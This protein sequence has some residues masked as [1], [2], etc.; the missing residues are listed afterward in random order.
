M[1]RATKDTRT[2]PSFVRSGTTPP[3]VSKIRPTH[4][5]RLAIVYV[6]QSSHRQVL[7]NRESTE[8]QYGLT[9]LAAS[10]GWHEDRILIIDDDQGQSGSTAEGRVG[11]QRLLAEVSLNHVGLVLGIEMS[12]LARSCKDWYH[13]LELCGVFQSLLADQDGLYDPA[14]YNDRLLLGLKGTMSEA[15][16]HIIRSR[17]DQGRRNKASRGELFGRL[18]FGYVFDSAGE[19]VKDP[20]E[21]VRSRVELIFEKFDEI[22][23]VRG[24]LL[25]LK[26]NQIKCPFVRYTQPAMGTVEWRYMSAATLYAL[27]KHPF[28]A[29]A[30]AWG[31]RKVDHRRRRPGQPSTG[32]ILQP[33]D[34]WDVLIR[35]RLPA[36]I[37]WDKYVAIQEQVRQNKST[38]S[39]PGA[40]RTS[41]LAGIVECGRCGW[42]MRMHQHS[43]C[44]ARQYQCPSRM[45]EHDYTQCQRLRTTVLDDLVTEKLFKAIEP[46]AL[47]LSLAAAANADAEGKRLLDLKRQELDRAKYLS[48]KA[49]RQY[50]AVDPENRLVAAEL[51]R[52]WEDALRDYRNRQDEFDRFSESKEQLELAGREQIAALSSDIPQLWHRDSTQP[53]DRQMLVR[54]LVEKI[55]VNVRGKTEMVDVAIHWSGGYVSHHEIR[56]PV[57]RYEFLADF[58]RMKS[59]IVELRREG[60]SAG[61][62]ATALNSEGFYPPRLDRQFNAVMVRM[63][64]QRFQLNGPRTDSINFEHL[65]KE[66]EWWIRDICQELKIPQSIMCKWC[67]RG[68]VKARKVMVTRRRWI[69]WADPPECDRLKRLHAHRRVGTKRTY[70]EE[71]TKPRNSD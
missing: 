30:Y 2:E 9:K 4:L 41:L 20:D 24:V 59:R 36:Y 16:L 22:G 37:S 46:A 3:G 49:R 33:Q 31:R 51:E 48:D 5:E 50:D 62:V 70:P 29:G 35:D 11:F 23:T 27:F 34:Q 6:R 28:Y 65:L 12:R 44:R 55:V 40:P 38:P 54:C 1:T 47:E 32:R 64:V 56:R 25:Y 17:M 66:H 61:E 60:H 8:L 42:I 63:L 52:Q 14:Q 18:P 19:V 68:W 10:Y 53:R 57:A 26:R 15:E 69:V 71:L 21:Q 7:N 45:T 13:L 43:T 67:A 58:E 39:T